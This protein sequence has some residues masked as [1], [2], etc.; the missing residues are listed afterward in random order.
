MSSKPEVSGFTRNEKFIME[1]LTEL[2]GAADD[3]QTR[4]AKLEAK[5][6]KNSH[7]SEAAL[8]KLKGRQQLAI[9]IVGGILTLVGLIIAAVLK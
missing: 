4:V 1:S 8:E 5:V 6:E 7:A 9:T 2:K 3:L